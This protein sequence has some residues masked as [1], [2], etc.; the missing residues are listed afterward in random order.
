MRPRQSRLELELPGTVVIIHEVELGRSEPAWVVDKDKPPADFA[1]TEGVRWRPGETFVDAAHCISV[2][3][4]AKTPKG[5]PSD[6]ER[7]MLVPRWLRG[8][9][10]FG[11]VSR[12]W[13]INW[14]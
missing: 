13:P 4:N 8:R 2:A 10:H 6:V 7:G 12:Q 3:V 5:V 11:M 14:P 9:G 1:D